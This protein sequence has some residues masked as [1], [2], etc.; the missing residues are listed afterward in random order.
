MDAGITARNL[1][2]IDAID[3]ETFDLP[4]TYSFGIVY[5][6]REISS[7]FFLPRFMID[8]VKV[9]SYDL[10]IKTGVE[11][12]LY[13]YV[14]ARAG[15]IAGIE[16]QGLSFGFGVNWERWRFDYGYTPLKEDLG[17]AQRISV[18]ATW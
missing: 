18:G 10:S 4:T 9:D 14:T 12:E 16:G 11:A 13:K 15:Y 17:S 1:G 8:A 3:Q 7:N 5:H 2:K 6:L